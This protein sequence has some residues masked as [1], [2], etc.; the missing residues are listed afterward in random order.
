MRVAKCA[1][2]FLIVF[3]FACSKDPFSESNIQSLY[4]NSM[5][6]KSPADK[7][8]W[9]KVLEVKNFKKIKGYDITPTEHYV[10]F[11]FDRLFRI[12]AA[13]IDRN[14]SEEELDKVFGPRRKDIVFDIKQKGFRAGDKD[15]SPHL[16]M[17]LQKTDSGWIVKQVGFP[18]D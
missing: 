8:R 13:D 2:F 14:F 16:A 17:V 10:E 9:E 11:S 12:N 18:K 4:V 5:A 7:F 3:V 6:S 15:A 1:V